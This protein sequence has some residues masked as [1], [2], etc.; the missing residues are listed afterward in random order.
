MPELPEVENT[1]RYLVKAGLP[2]RTLTGAYI[3]WTK[4]VQRPSLDAFVTGLKDGRVQAV[5]R[6]GKYIL[7]N[8]HKVDSPT[9]S[10]LIIHLGMTG[11]LRIQPN[12]QS[13]HPLLRHSFP[14]D[15]GC[16]LRFIDGRK[17]GKLWL[18]H[19]PEDVLP[20]LGP[21][22][23]G[24][25]FT[26]DWLDPQSWREKR[27][28]QSTAAGAVHRRGNG[29][30]LRRRVL[31]LSGHPPTEA[32][33]GAIGGGNHTAAGG[34][35][36]CPHIGRPE[37]RRKPRRTLARPSLRAVP[38]VHPPKRWRSLLPLRR[39]HLGHPS[40]GPGHLFL[41]GVPGVGAFVAVAHWGP[42][43]VRWR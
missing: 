11:E 10:T 25:E 24:G 12:S 4:A 7:V 39:V 19:E 8:L 1:R 40:P 42:L 18:A 33:R 38:L 16:E 28:G 21:E 26:S 34:H 27:P 29:E 22:P 14:L 2:G 17:F 35:Y 6:R 30:P 32:R 3:G 41:S 36:R 43:T 5:G 9:A 31:V 13:V 15:D 23:L 20:R 37:V